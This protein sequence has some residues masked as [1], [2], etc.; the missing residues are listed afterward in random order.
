M[1]HYSE[2]L[3]QRMLK[4]GIKQEQLDQLQAAGI[5]AADIEKHFTIISAV[6][7]PFARWLDYMEQNQRMVVLSR[8][9]IGLFSNLP[10]QLT[11]VAHM[12]GAVERFKAASG[13]GNFAEDEVR[14][15]FPLVNAHALVFFWSSLEALIDDF[16]FTWLIQVHPDCG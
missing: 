3:I 11:A 5:S 4:Y 2:S 12:P 16:V 10:D 7:A 15:G 1:N 8:V 13:Y 9:G 6:Y 14:K